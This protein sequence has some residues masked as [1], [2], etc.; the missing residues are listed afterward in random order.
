[1]D[2]GRNSLTERDGSAALH[3]N[4]SHVLIYFCMPD[5][6]SQTSSTSGNSGLNAAG[7]KHDENINFLPLNSTTLNSVT[8]SK[9][10]A[11]NLLKMKHFA[12]NLRIFLNK[13]DENYDIQ[14]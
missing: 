9:A 4:T 5:K 14:T 12:S 2:L 11:T 6:T 10:F 8:D 13:L 3:S 7:I 1:M